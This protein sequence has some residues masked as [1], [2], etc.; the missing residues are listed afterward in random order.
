MRI[1]MLLEVALAMSF[2]TIIITVSQEFKKQRDSSHTV[3]RPFTF[4]LEITIKEEPQI[5]II[6]FLAIFYNKA[7]TPKWFLPF[8]NWTLSSPS[9][10]FS[11]LKTSRYIYFLNITATVTGYFVIEVLLQVSIVPLKLLKPLQSKPN[12]FTVKTK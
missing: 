1:V 7:F 2:A 11:S 6:T 4:R 3:Y 10:Y 12:T 5:E 9:Q 8:I